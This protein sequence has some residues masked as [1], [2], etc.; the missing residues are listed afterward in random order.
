M[1]NRGSG[2]LAWAKDHLGNLESGRSGKGL[3]DWLGQGWRVSGSVVG[4]WC[5]LLGILETGRHQRGL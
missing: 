4:V 3:R 2:K 1:G 5:G